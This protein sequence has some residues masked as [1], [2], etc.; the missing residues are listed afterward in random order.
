[1]SAALELEGLGVRFDG[2]WVLRG[3]S[4]RLDPGEKVV[5]T[6]PSGTGKS[7][8][9]R[10]AMGLAVPDE[11]GVRVF[12]EPMDGRSVWALRRRMAY[13][14]QEPDLGPGTAGEAVRRP[15]GYRANAALRGNLDRLPALLERFHLAPDLLAKE[16]SALSGGE[17]QRFA[18]I[19]ALLLDRSI[20]LLDEASSALDADNRKRVTDGFAADASTTVLAVA[21]DETWGRFASRVVTVPGGRG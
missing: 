5:L 11:G 20:V 21:H 14:A 17:K 2:R 9:L 19:V 7:T 10:C 8:V 1:M 16:T 18:I 3:F 6:G 13:V 15:F 12:G 4:L